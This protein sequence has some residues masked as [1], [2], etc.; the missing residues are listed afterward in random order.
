MRTTL[1]RASGRCTASR[2]RADTPP[3]VPSVAL[4]P[5]GRGLLELEPDVDGAAPFI[6]PR[7]GVEHDRVVG[8]DRIGCVQYQAVPTNVETHGG[9]TSGTWTCRADFLQRAKNGS[10]GRSQTTR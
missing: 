9:T 4:G 10:T 2:P 7:R 3:L 1:W 5:R 8:R 6:E